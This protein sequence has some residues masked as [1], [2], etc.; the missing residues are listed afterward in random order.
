MKLTNRETR[1][2][3]KYFPTFSPSL[4]VRVVEWI[5]SR[6]WKS[7]RRVPAAIDLLLEHDS[8]DYYYLSTF[9]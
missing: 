1:Y 3:Y 5:T 6:N 7:N 8:V 4:D 9:L 2:I